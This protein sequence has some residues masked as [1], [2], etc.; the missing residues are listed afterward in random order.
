MK[1]E[2]KVALVGIAA[3]FILELVALAT[4]INGMVL[5]LSIAG[6]AGLAGYVMPSPLFKR[7][8]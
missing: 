8:R 6:I 4:G 2:E 3:I 5:G 1:S 7:K